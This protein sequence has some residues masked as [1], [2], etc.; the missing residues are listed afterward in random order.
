VAAPSGNYT[1][2]N[3][4]TLPGYHATFEL[5]FA[6][7]VTWKYQLELRA[8]GEAVEA[9]LHIEGPSRAQNPGDVRMVTAGGA[10]RML[11][12]GTDNQC[13]QFPSDMDLGQAFVTPDHLI[14][15]V[16]LAPAL[17]P[18]GEES[19]LGLPTE[20]FTASQSGLGR[21]QE[22]QIG[23]W[24]AKEQ[25]AVLVY[26]L[27]LT[28][29]DPLF[30]GGPGTLAGTFR[31]QAVGQQAIEPIQG[32]AP[33]LPLPAGASRLVLLPGLISFDSAASPEEIAAFY[34]AELPGLGWQAES[35]PQA[36][37]NALV[38]AFTRREETLT[39]NIENRRSG[40]EVELLFPERQ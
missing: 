26:D 20:H 27:L 12:P 7:D 32:C 38:L 4:E 5:L 2:L 17:D 15:P 13:V 40:V 22:A 25:G 39:V 36:G 8:D 34:Q 31:V 29:A 1:G 21:W 37:G 18:A 35:E 23:L 11:G 19:L 9:N 16:V 10:S 33:A 3:L 30:G 14:P 28:G 24:R 6:G